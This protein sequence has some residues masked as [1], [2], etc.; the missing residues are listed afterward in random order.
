[1]SAETHRDACHQCCGPSTSAT[2]VTARSQGVLMSVLRE[3]ELARR[4]TSWL[5]LVAMAAVSL[6]IAVAAAVTPRTADPTP[7]PVTMTASRP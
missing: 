6:A 7:A 5:M 4:A 1:M 2:C 3:P